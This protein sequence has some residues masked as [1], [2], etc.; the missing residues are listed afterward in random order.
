MTLVTILLIWIILIISVEA[1]TEIVTSSNIFLS[2]REWIYLK[3]DFL[4]K[5]I[6][7]GYCTSVWISAMVAWAA[8]TPFHPIFGYFIALFAI[9]R[10]S[11]LW[12]EFTVR[13]LNRAPIAISLFTTTEQETNEDN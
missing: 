6:Q 9:H 10:L 1:V 5:L 13:W 4:G 11:N 12:H 7:C 8:P 3:S 2:L